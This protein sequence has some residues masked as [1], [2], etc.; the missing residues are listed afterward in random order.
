MCDNTL[1]YQNELWKSLFL[2]SET[3]GQ[4]AINV[5]FDAK[6]A[7]LFSLSD[8]TLANVSSHVRQ[9]VKVI[10][11]ANVNIKLSIYSGK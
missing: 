3:P 9:M 2:Y 7:E 10:Q 6:N 8:V 5:G 11:L 4:N 1:S